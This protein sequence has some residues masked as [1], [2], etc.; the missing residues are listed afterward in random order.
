MRDFI[1]LTE[2]PRRYM[3]LP[4]VELE[5]PGG[6]PAALLGDVRVNFFHYASFAEGAARWEER[7]RKINWTRLVLIAAD[8]GSCDYETLMR[9]DRLPCPYK[10]IFTHRSCPEI[11]SAVYIKGFENC[12]QVGILTDFKPGLLMRRYLDDFDYVGFLNG[13]K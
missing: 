5:N 2:N 12:G 7:K 9:F 4:L 6:Y 8:R 13:V 11:S 3:D 1:R 10:V